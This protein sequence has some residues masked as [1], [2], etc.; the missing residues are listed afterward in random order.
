MNNV[1]TSKD[2]IF[3]CDSTNL[4]NNFQELALES[5]NNHGV[6]YITGIYTRSEVEV[7]RNDL[8]L[9]ERSGSE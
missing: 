9:F 5:Y 8:D 4:P 7:L 3:S 6:F 2:A 1:N